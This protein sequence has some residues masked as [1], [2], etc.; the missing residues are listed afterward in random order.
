MLGYDRK[1][2]LQVA[3][4]LNGLSS[5]TAELDDGIISG[6]IHPGAPVFTALLAV[7]EQRNIDFEHFCKGVV[8]GYEASTRMANAI[9]P[10]HKKK[11]YH[12]SAT[13]GMLGVT[14]GVAVMLDYSFWNLKNA[15]SA[16]VAT[17]HGTLKVLEDNSELKPYNV[18][19]AAKDGIEAAFVG[20]LFNGPVDPLEGYAGFLAQATDEVDYD[21]LFQGLNGKYCIEDVYTKPYAA[22]RYCHPSIENV[23]KLQSETN[24]NP[25]DIERIDIRTYSLA[26]DKHDNTTV[27]N[28]SA[29]KMSIPFATAVTFCKGSA[30][31]DAY[32]DDTVN[33]PSVNSLMR[34]VHVA[35]DEDFSQAFPKLSIATMKVTTTDGHVFESKTDLPKG[36]AVNPM[37]DEELADKFIS[38]ACWSGLNEEKAKK[39]AEDILTHDIN[40]KALIEHLK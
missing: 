2:L 38:L 27:G 20:S 15:F 3:T 39:I 21:K 23:L 9:Q 5:H 37:T 6:I 17:T 33:D 28:V 14:V 24:I 18:A 4:L 31:V 32:S 26:V 40:I 8:A 19:M 12:A 29:A 30:S 35:A 13:C 36:E 11:G 25:D 1:A 34:K 10:S 22:C 16:A 7:A